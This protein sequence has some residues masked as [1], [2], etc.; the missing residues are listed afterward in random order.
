MPL[1]EEIY[2]HNK[3]VQEAIDKGLPKTKAAKIPFR[4]EMSAFARHENSIP[5]VGDIGKVWPLLAAGVAKNLGIGLEF[6]SASQ[7]TPEGSAMR[8]WIVDNVKPLDREKML[9]R[10]K[11]F[12]I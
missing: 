1:Q 10:S 3:I 7:D 9:A 11:E 6:L 5:I 12:C 8:E 4:M 2:I